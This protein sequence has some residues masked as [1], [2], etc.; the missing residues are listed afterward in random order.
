M[1]LPY[2]HYIPAFFLHTVPGLSIIEFLRDV[3]LDPQQNGW[4]CVL[5]QIWHHLLYSLQILCTGDTLEYF[6]FT[7]LYVQR[8]IYNSVFTKIPQKSLEKDRPSCRS[9][10]TS[11]QWSRLNFTTQL[12]PLP[13]PTPP[14]PPPPPPPPPQRHA[15][16]ESERTG[17]G[18]FR[19]LARCLVASSIHWLLQ[20]RTKW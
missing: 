19:K 14:R 9:D 5:S 4:M 7:N 20:T 2:A 1:K 17:D 11:I 8:W 13:P 16:H 3:D 15:V 12:C 6:T 18:D 10:D